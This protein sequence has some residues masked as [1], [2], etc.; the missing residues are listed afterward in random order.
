M[1]WP[2]AYDV[3]LLLRVK[4]GPLRDEEEGQEQKFLE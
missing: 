1:Y 3:Q 2:S 4:E